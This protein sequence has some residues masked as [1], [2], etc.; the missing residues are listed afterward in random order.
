MALSFPA[1]TDLAQHY[2]QFSSELAEAQSLEAGTI[3]CLALLDLVF[4]P[5]AVQIVWG[6]GQNVRVLGSD[7]ATPIYPADEELAALQHGQPV[8][9]S[10]AD[11]LQACFV[12]LRA[13][14]ELR[15]WL[16]RSRAG[17]AR[18]GGPACRPCWPI[19]YAERYRAPAQRRAG[20][21]YAVG[22]D[23]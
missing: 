4:A 22:G 20:S 19:A 12:P 8:L 10:Q 23:L 5:Q 3:C 17:H 11:Q 15:G 16:Y 1:E 6:T 18:S 14:A 13:R 2:S 9:R 21:R 7:I